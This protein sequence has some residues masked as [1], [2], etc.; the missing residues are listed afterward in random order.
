MT[1]ESV[2]A[3]P[4]VMIAA[5]LFFPISSFMQFR[6]MMRRYLRAC[7]ICT[8]SL[9]G[10]RAATVF[11]EKKDLRLIAQMDVLPH[12]RTRSKIFIVDSHSNNN[13]TL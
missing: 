10:E 13:D 8:G 9:F 2:S 3:N 6:S 7:Q 12:Q 4:V 5:V 11:T 1:D